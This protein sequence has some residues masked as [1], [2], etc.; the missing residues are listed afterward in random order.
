[1]KFAFVDLGPACRCGSTDILDVVHSLSVVHERADGRTRAVIDIEPVTLSVKI[2][3]EAQLSDLSVQE[4][5]A[6][7]ALMM[8]GLRGYRPCH[9]N[10]EKT[11][12]RE[13]SSATIAQ[14]FLDVVLWIRER[15]NATGGHYDGKKSVLGLAIAR[16]DVVK[17][18]S[19]TVGAKRPCSGKELTPRVI[20]NL[21]CL[22]VLIL[23]F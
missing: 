15:D 1:M 5:T 13:I 18:C 3:A 6:Y 14:V 20:A 19:K 10:L 8:E 9:I 23:Q 21:I 7:V 16:L 11:N 12:L 17:E 4:R 2:C 22:P